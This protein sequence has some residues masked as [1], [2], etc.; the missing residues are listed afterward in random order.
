M[1]VFLHLPLLT[2][3]P[4]LITGF[5]NPHQHFYLPSSTDLPT[6]LN[7]FDYLTYP[8]LTYPNRCSG[9]TY[10][11]HRIYLP[12]S[13]DLPTLVNLICFKVTL[14]HINIALQV[15]SRIIRYYYYCVGFVLK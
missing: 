5:T 2:D 8:N 6:L 4:T 14:K 3:A 7:V 11:R 1:N 15:R 13:T 10:P 9:F 12:S